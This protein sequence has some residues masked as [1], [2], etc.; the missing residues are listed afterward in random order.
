VLNNQLSVAL[1]PIVAHFSAFH[2][3]V[4]TVVLTVMHCSSL[5]PQPFKLDFLQNIPVMGLVD[6]G[7]VLWYEAGFEQ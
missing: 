2:S 1:L 5:P 7:R 3:V 6:G 4:V